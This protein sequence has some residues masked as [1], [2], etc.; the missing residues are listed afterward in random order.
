MLNVCAQK[1]KPVVKV[2]DSNRRKTVKMHVINYANIFYILKNQPELANIVQKHST[3]IHI[4]K[5]LEYSD[6][7]P[8]LLVLA[9]ADNINKGVFTCGE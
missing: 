6:K 1:G 2:V 9:T 5:L 7:R 3:L 4:I 8:H